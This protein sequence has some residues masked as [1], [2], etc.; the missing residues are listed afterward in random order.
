MFR[1]LDFTRSGLW[2]EHRSEIRPLMEFLG[3]EHELDEVCMFFSLLRHFWLSRILYLKTSI[4]YLA[5]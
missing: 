1:L 2:P 3:G 5:F 4:L